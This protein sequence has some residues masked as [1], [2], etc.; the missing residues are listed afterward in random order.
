MRAPHIPFTGFYKAL[1]PDLGKL[2][3]VSFLCFSILDCLDLK[4]PTGFTV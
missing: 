3:G 4:L 2:A 1:I